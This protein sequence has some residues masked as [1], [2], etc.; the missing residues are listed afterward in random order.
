M[1]FALD[2]AQQALRSTVRAF[3]ADQVPPA[4]VRS[5]IEHDRADHRRALG[6]LAALGWTGLLVPE[7]H[8]GSGAGM[9]EMMVV[10]EEMG[11]LP[12]PG[13]FLSSAVLAALADRGASGWWS[14]C[15]AWPTA[16]RA[17]PSRTTRTATAT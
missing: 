13:P 5:V 1:E 7:E 15:P 2:E 10:L 16:R 4:Y 14:C 17:A 11:R 12:L 8:G 6:Q 3:L 9:L